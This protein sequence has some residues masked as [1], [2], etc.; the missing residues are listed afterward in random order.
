[1]ISC[2][3]TSILELFLE[4]WYKRESPFRLLRNIEFLSYNFNNSFVFFWFFYF[5]AEASVLVFKERTSDG[6]FYLTIQSLKHWA[7]LEAW[8]RKL[9]GISEYHVVDAILSVMN[10]WLRKLQPWRSDLLYDTDGNYLSWV[11]WYISISH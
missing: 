3:G 6:L 11:F 1:M 5:F 8:K 9:Q 2:R 7:I 4:K 10:D